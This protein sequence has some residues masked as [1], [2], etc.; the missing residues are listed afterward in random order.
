MKAKEVLD[1]LKISRQTLYQ[2]T[3]KG[4]IKKV[5]KINGQYAYD[6]E[7][8]YNIYKKG[9]KKKICGYARVET[10]GEVAFLEEQ[11]RNIISFCSRNGWCVD[12]LFK[13]IRYEN[14]FNG[15]TVLYD[16]F[17]EISRDKI[18]HLIMEDKTIIDPSIFDFFINLCKKHDTKLTFLL[19]T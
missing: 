18:T 13:E 8:V 9:N 15:A 4:L 17:E 3:K 19:N 11:T 2:Y 16:V 12:Y 14:Y 5:V 7:S 1:L 6:E 10:S